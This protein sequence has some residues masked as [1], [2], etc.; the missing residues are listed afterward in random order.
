M[1]RTDN[2]TRRK[3]LGF[4]LTA[5]VA[6]PVAASLLG[7]RSASAQTALPHVDGATDP[8]GMA[9]GYSE[10]AT[11]VDTAKFPKRAGDEGA[12][13]FCHSCSLFQGKEGEDFATCTMFPGK[14]VSKNGWCNAWAP[15]AA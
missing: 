7:A 8:V 9:L 1:K 4:G 10:D 12:K 6:A 15:K 3:F 5:L 11:K 13:Q 14:A 2:V